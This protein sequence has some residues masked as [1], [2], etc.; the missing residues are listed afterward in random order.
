MTLTVSRYAEHTL[1]NKPLRCCSNWL[2]SACT[3]YQ[4]LMPGLLLLCCMPTN[5]AF[6]V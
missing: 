1:I 5:S 3:L 4:R 2:L 6:D